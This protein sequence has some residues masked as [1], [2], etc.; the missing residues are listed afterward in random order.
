MSDFD[1]IEPEEIVAALREWAKE[2]VKRGPADRR[3]L[4]R[5]LFTVSSA[6]IGILLTLAKLGP[7]DARGISPTLV[8]GLLVLLGS[9]LTAI[10]MARPQ[11]WRAGPKT[12][13]LEEYNRQVAHVE[14]E[15]LLWVVSWGMGTLLGA[16]AIL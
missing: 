3:E 7:A 13:L 10:H 2:E 15:S 5:F 8:V 12:S 6:T 4:G 1:R 16:A 9:I 11:V 14:T